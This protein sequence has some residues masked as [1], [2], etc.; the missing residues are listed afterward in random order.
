MNLQVSFTSKNVSSSLSTLFALTASFSLYHN[1]LLRGST[2]L[3]QTLTGDACFI[4]V[5]IGSYTSLLFVYIECSKYISFLIPPTLYRVPLRDTLFI[6]VYCSLFAPCLE[7]GMKNE[8]SPLVSVCV[9]RT[10]CV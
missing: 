6:S 1:P 3:T 8:F 4:S 7:G 5:L 10:F 2:C 9:C